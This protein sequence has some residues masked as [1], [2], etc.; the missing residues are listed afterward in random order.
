M[1]EGEGGGGYNICKMDK[2][3]HFRLFFSVSIES[4][5]YLDW[6]VLGSRCLSMFE[7]E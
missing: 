1:L 2:T 7:L 6:L 3:V 5:S 4:I